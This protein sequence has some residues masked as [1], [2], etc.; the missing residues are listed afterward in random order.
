MAKRRDKYISWDKAHKAWV[1]RFN[2]LRKQST[3]KWKVEHWLEQE[4]K[5][6][7]AEGWD[8]SELPHARRIDA[9]KAVKLLPPGYTLEEAAQFF[10]DHLARTTRTLTIAEAIAEFLQTKKK[11]SE[12][13]KR[14]LTT[15]LN[16]WKSFLDRENLV[17][18]TRPVSSVTASELAAFVEQFQG[19]TYINWHAVVSPSVARQWWRIRPKKRR[20]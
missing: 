13:H 8:A 9:I 6:K 5:K 3:L 20:K 17:S 11:V 2:G 15:R 7:E 14:D 1:A 16:R 18:S 10:A 4:T 12:T 19:Q